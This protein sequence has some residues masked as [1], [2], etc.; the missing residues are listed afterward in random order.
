MGG[1]ESLIQRRPFLSGHAVPDGEDDEWA[2]SEDDGDPRAC[3]A[4]HYG[5]KSD[6][7]VCTVRYEGAWAPVVAKPRGKRPRLAFC[8][9]LSCTP[10]AWS[11]ILAKNINR[12][13]GEERGLAAGTAG[14]RRPVSVASATRSQAT[15]VTTRTRP[16]AKR[17]SQLRHTRQ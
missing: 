12:I 8:F 13:R 9:Q 7:P 16:R 17:Q 10:H 1:L 15:S 3:E 6:L 11:S 4:G 14:K 2:D 5:P